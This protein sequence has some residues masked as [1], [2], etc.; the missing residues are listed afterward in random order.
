MEWQEEGIVLSAARYG[1]SDALLEV[2]TRGHGRYRGY[3]KGG[4]GK[5]QRASLQPGNRLSLTWRSRLQEN[6]G[7]FTAELI[8]S[9]LGSLI[10]NGPRLSA[11]TAF[12]AVISS[13]IPEREQHVGVFD[14]L[15]AVVT[16]LEHDKADL[17]MLG[18]ALAKLELGILSELGYGLDLKS[19][20]ATGCSDDLVYV[21]PKSA[22]AVSRPAGEPYKDRLLALP[23]FIVTE[24]QENVSL[25]D[26]L[27]GL[28]LTAYFLDRHVWVSHGKGQPPGRER[29]TASLTRQSVKA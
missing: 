29:F 26:V 14:T 1:E 28:K 10:S 13:S 23:D 21:S 18:A 15:E 19:C 24:G 25:D 12:T 5:R 27:K 6:L 17:I 2:M 11:L 9:P 3:V 8:H 20:A 7:R 16:I 22:R 4:S